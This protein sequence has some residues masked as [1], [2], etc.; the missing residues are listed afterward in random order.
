MQIVAGFFLAGREKILA[1]NENQ[2]AFRTAE[3]GALFILIERST[4]RM[5]AQWSSL[6]WL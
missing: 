1:V 4:F 2:A 5:I 3:I 6:F